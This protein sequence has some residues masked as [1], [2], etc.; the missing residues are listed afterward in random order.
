LGCAHC[1]C[2]GHPPQQACC[3]YGVLCAVHRT[4]RLWREDRC[5][6]VL[7]GHEGPVLALAVLE[8]GDLL[9]GSGD[10]TIKRWQGT[11][12]VATYKG[13]TDTVRCAC[14]T[15]G[16]LVHAVM[17]ARVRPASHCN[18]CTPPPLPSTPAGLFYVHAA[19]RAITSRARAP[20]P[21]KTS[22]RRWTL[23]L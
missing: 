17:P 18:A 7:E 13:H 4:I 12:C 5:A 19:A 23:C 20:R 15:G 10:T 3:V 22:S 21:S 1:N 11:K 2:T 6:A 16:L 8:G 9:S 14:G